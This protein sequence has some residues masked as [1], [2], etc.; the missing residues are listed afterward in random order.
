ME[1]VCKGNLLIDKFKNGST[2]AFEEIVRQY[3]EKAYSLAY[4]FIGNREDA[5]D[6]SQDA[7]VIVYKKA[8]EFRGESSFQTWFYKIIVNLCRNHLRRRRWKKVI[9]LDSRENKMDEKMLIDE[10]SAKADTCDVKYSLENMELKQ[11]I[12]DAIK[13]LPAQQKEVFIMKHF[14]EMKISEIA[15]CL[16]C[17]EGTVKSHLFRAVKNLQDMLKGFVNGGAA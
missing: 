14:Q 15:K 1:I 8:S 4:H 6:I 12:E 7:F 17:A 11:A 3:R 9:G 10:I 5:E 2:E 13:M 16:Q